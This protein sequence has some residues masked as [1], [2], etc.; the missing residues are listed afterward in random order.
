MSFKKEIQA[1]LEEIHDLENE[2][3]KV[4]DL[5]TLPL[6]FFSEVCDSLKILTSG[7]QDIE[8]MQTERMQFQMEHHKIAFAELANTMRDI[9]EQKMLVPKK[10]AEK[11][12]EKESAFETSTEFLSAKAPLKQKNTEDKIEQKEHAFVG[13]ANLSNSFLGD[14]IQKQLSVDLT[15]SISVNDKFRFRRDLFGGKAEQLNSALLSL[16]TFKT[17]EEALKFL[18]ENYSWDQ[19]NETLIAFKDLLEKRFI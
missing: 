18:N 14:R 16:N 9:F 10:N 7:F 12:I 13:K 19:N 2:F 15:K 1:L 6:S 11:N 4:K 8:K 17:M 5:E 3:R